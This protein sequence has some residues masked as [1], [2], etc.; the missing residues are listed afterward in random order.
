M[1]HAQKGVI[2][3]FV[4]KTKGLTLSNVEVDVVRNHAPLGSL[5]CGDY[6]TS[7][8]SSNSGYT[9]S[10]AYGMV[11]TSSRDINIAGL[12][13]DGVLSGHAD[14]Y[15]AALFNNVGRRLLGRARDQER[16]HRHHVRAE[17]PAAQSR[18]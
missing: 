3:L 16:E 7:Q 15:G 6:L 13:I 14:A 5:A 4:Q 11:V 12:T 9:G 1:H 17:R 18:A 8:W 10:Q 2:G